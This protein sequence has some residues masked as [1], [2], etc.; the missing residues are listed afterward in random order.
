MSYF[1]IGVSALSAAQMGLST[2]AHNISN[3]NTEGFHRQA[4]VQATNIPVGTGSGFVGQGVNVDTVKRIYSQ[5]LDNQVLQSQ[6]RSS[7]FNSYLSSINQIDNVVANASAGLSPALQDFF[8]AVND[9]ANA[10]QSVSSRQALLSTASA[11]V[12]RFQS[13]QGRFSEIQDGLNSQLSGSVSA[14]NTYATQIAKLNDQIILQSGSFN[15][16]ANDLLDQRDAL[17]LK[18]SEQVRTTTIRQ[19]NGAL[20]VF[21]GNGQPLVVDQRAFALTAVVSPDDPRRYEVAYKSGGNAQLLPQGALTGGVIGG[22][23]D[24]RS[25]TLD[26]AANAL[27]RIALALAGTFNTQHR[28]GQDL[29]GALGGDFFALP[30]PT[31]IFSSKNTGSGALTAAVGDVNLL[32]T[33]DYR[34]EFDGTDYVVTDLASKTSS[35]VLA[36]NLATAIPG[37]SLSMAGAPAA[38]D[39]FTVQ[40]T[41]Y[42]ARDI[43]LASTLNTTTIA[44]AA[45]LSVNAVLSN[46]GSAR[47]TSSTVTN[48][49]GLPLGANITLT[50][51]SATNEFAVAGAVPAVANISYTSGTPMT[52]NG[53][54][55]T[56]SGSPAEGDVFTIGNNVNGVSDNRN[57]L[58][59]AR[60]QTM[61]TMLGGTASYQGAYGQMVSQIGNTTAAIQASAKAEENLLM[62]SRNSQQAL[63]GVNLDEEAA[64]LLRYQQAYQAAGKMLQIASTLFDSLLA[65]GR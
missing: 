16:P 31:V 41:R 58:L 19:D 33:S 45:P 11:M 27:G 52:V 3:V 14:I 34:V 5:F 1:S 40:P 8:K 23:L 48:V 25:E 43:A 13:L 32:T 17:V 56:L 50:Y 46:T 47:V 61:N 53:L 24:F 15:Q 59:L 10:P 54:I 39:V 63:S 42:A 9:V 62:S 6:T 37:L 36:A 22:L 38:G 4:I 60:L 51:D 29:N 28:L 12:S 64:N 21:I 49:S 35:T 55:L 30:T 65:I 20:N 57:A 7:S 18:L 44:A 2:T 26:Q